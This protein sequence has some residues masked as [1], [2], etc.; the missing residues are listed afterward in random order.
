MYRISFYHIGK[1]SHKSDRE[2]STRR[3]NPLELCAL[4]SLY[5]DVTIE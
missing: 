3:Y 1:I 2:K 4:V 5:F